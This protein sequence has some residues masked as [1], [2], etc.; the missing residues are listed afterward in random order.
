M[1]I[2]NVTPDSFSD[3][4]LYLDAGRA[5]ERGFEM[6]D[7]GA[8]IIDVGGEST[9][10]GSSGV[11]AKEEIRRVVPVIRELAGRL[12]VPVSCDTTK[13]AV[14]AAAIEAGAAIINDI[15][16]FRFDAGM[17]DVI[18]GSGCA[19]V[20]MHTSGRPAEMQKRTEYGDIFEDILEYLKSGIEI[21]EARGFPASNIIVDPGIGFGKTAGQNV[22]II[23]GLR[24]FSVLGKPIMAGPSRKSFIGHYTGKTNPGDRLFGTCGAAAAA[25]MNGANFLRVHDVKEC[26][27]LVKIVDVIVDKTDFS[28]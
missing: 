2:L 27:D 11:G 23:A 22:M 21:L 20:C 8:D 6:A 28:C 19:A 15:S 14:A 26:A 13:S 7:E 12:K 5:I 9:R 25:V 16:G 18:A 24:K 4:G 3:G 10:P 1:G 17:A